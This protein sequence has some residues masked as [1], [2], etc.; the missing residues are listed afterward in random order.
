ML[1][2]LVQRYE[3][4]ILPCIAA[5]FF[6]FLFFSEMCDIQ[7]CFPLLK[8]GLKAQA[9]RLAGQEACTG[10]VFWRRQLPNMPWQC[11]RLVALLLAA[12]PVTWRCWSEGHV[13]AVL[14]QTWRWGSRRRAARSWPTAGTCAARSCQAAA[15][16]HG[17]FGSTDSWELLPG[18]FLIFLKQKKA[19]RMLCGQ[20]SLWFFAVI[21]INA[22]KPLLQNMWLSLDKLQSASCWKATGVTVPP[23]NT[24]VLFLHCVLGASNSKHCLVLGMVL[25]QT[26]CSWYVGFFFSLFYLTLSLRHCMEPGSQT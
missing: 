10:L 18:G 23:N 26:C 5:V 1:H 9:V 24:P 8:A 19:Q 11:V 21:K 25:L 16:W 4:Q 2:E 20:V 17:C 3:Y 14:G 7:F 15:A 13:S 12:G 6:I 22:V